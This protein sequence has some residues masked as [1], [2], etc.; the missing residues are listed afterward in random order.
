MLEG[1]SLLRVFR[2][3][4]KLRVI[5]IA[6]YKIFLQI[7]AEVPTL[8]TWYLTWGSSPYFA[9]PICFCYVSNRLIVYLTGTLFEIAMIFS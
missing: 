9:V 3:W 2:I 6:R 5:L 4:L 7:V 1:L 8:T